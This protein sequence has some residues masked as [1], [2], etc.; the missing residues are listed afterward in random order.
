MAFHIIGKTTQ[1]TMDRR[2]SRST[3]SKMTARTTIAGTKDGFKAIDTTHYDEEA[4]TARYGLCLT[5]ATI[6]LHCSLEICDCLRML[7]SF[8]SSEIPP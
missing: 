5:S 1:S 2:E 8:V 4:T 6:I 7:L 3:L